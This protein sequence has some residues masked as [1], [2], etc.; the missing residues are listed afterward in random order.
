[1]AP[2]T[3]WWQ[4]SGGVPSG[5]IQGAFE[6][7]TVADNDSLYL[8]KLH[9]EAAID[10]TADATQLFIQNGQLASE[11]IQAEIPRLQLIQGAKG[12]ELRT[13]Q[14]ELAPLMTV[15]VASQILPESANTMLTGLKPTGRVERLSLA[16]DALTDPF[17]CVGSGSRGYRCCDEALPQG[18]WIGRD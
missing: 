11:E 12:W 8:K 10:G 16:I 9:F 4:A 6:N 5:V 14:F 18:S 1:M 17:Q 15:L 3:F 7:L 2:Q 13:Q